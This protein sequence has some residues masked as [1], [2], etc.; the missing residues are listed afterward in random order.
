MPSSLK[1]DSK[2]N[3]LLK[4]N[5]VG[6]RQFRWKI[7]LDGQAQLHARRISWI[8]LDQPAWAAPCAS[9][10]EPLLGPFDELRKIMLRR[11]KISVSQR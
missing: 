11:F 4:E 7:Q 8:S 10:T 5:F 9:S 2:L 3:E 6:C 1:A